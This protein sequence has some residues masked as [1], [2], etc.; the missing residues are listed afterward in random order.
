MP[1]TRAI[2]GPTDVSFG[3]AE[4]DQ[5]EQAH[6]ADVR[7]EEEFLYI[8]EFHSNTSRLHSAPTVQPLTAVTPSEESNLKRSPTLLC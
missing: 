2:H 1:I 7:K 8:F 4:A 6:D 3:I 5:E